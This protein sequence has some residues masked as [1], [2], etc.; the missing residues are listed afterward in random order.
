MINIRD[1]LIY[2]L[3][4]IVIAPNADKSVFEGLEYSFGNVVPFDGSIENTE[5]LISFIKNNVIKQLVFV[6]YFD[7]YEEVINSLNEEFVA[8]FIFTH[9]L[10]ELSDQTLNENHGKVVKLYERGVVD[11]IGYLDPYLM[12]AMKKKGLKAKHIV[13]DVPVSPK[14]ECNNN[15]I[16]GV[17]NSGESNYDSFYNELCGISLIKGYSARVSKKTS[18]VFDFIKEYGL[19][20]IAEPDFQKL[21]SG[22]CC[23][24]CVNFSG[25]QP[26]VFLKSMDAGVPCIVGNNFFL[27][28]YGQLKEQL[29]VKSDDNVNEIVKMIKG[30][31]DNVEMIMKEYNAFRKEYSKISRKTVQ[32]FLVGVK[33]NNQKETFEKELSVIVP[34][35]NTEKYLDKCLDSVYKARIKNMEVLIIDDGSTDNSASIAKTYVEKYPDL[36][37]YVYKENGGLG[38]VRNVGLKE[39]KGKYLASV[40]SDDSIEQ[41]FFKEAALYMEKDVDVIVCDWLSVGKDNSFETPAID[42]V[43]KN[44]KAFAGL[45]Y[46]TIM[47]STCNKIIK[48]E[49]F[50]DN[51]ITYLEGKYEDLSANVFA[52]LKA[53]TLKY[54]NKPYYNYYL[55]DNSLMRSKVNPR[56]MADVVKYVWDKLSKMDIN[57]DRE[58]FYYYTFSWRIEELVFNPLYDLET[59]TKKEVL[60]IKKNIQSIITDIFDNEFYATMLDNLHSNK[61]A[62]YIKKRNDAFKKGHLDSFIKEPGEKFKLTPGII[63]YG[64]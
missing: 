28:G 34:V 40:D 29:M 36:F 22:N 64:D 61:M 7:V 12:R 3:D 33:E 32:Q 1:D 21:V 6:D 37:R 8:K 20:C 63:Y 46:T 10:G 43:F 45:M 41:E 49:L 5:Y 53:R 18:A 16:V 26:T 17:L 57:L 59:D 14:Q 15:K 48:K 52:L 42:P 31:P 24:I 51:N 54:L 9:Y 44:E 30:V 11:E 47:P 23:N 38:S 19:E 55:R 4:Y 60:Y 25:T 35:Y 58:A 13:L 39:A 56:E 27:T 62:E 50:V 2:N